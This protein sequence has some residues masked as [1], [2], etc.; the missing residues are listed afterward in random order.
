[1]RLTEAHRP[2]PVTSSTEP[3]AAQRWTAASRMLAVDRLHTVHSWSWT[4]IAAVAGTTRQAAAQRWGARRADDRSLLVQA[5]ELRCPPP[6]LI[7]PLGDRGGGAVFSRSGKTDITVTAGDRHAFVAEC[8]VWGGAAKFTEAVDQLLSYLV[9]RDSG[10]SRPWPAAARS[11]RASATTRT[12]GSGGS[13]RASPPTPPDVRA[14]SG[15]GSSRYSPSP[16][17]RGC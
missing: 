12:A 14:R 9:W 15:R 7:L 8:K 10:V 17:R 2:A 13:P 5:E 11:R 4:D 1:M 16:R 6:D 3:A